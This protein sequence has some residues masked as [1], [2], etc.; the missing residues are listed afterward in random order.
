MSH[1]PGPW[2]INHRDGST[3][4]D[5]PEGCIMC[6]EQYYPWTPDK[7]EDWRLIAASPDMLALLKRYVAE[8]PCAPGD[9]RYKEALALIDRV[10]LQGAIP[11]F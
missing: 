4:L 10:E 1:T 8:D 6:D 11:P 3:K 9:P 2:T 7:D 5:T